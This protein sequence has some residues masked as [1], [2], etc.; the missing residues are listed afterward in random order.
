MSTLQYPLGQFRFDP[1]TCTEQRQ[2]LIREYGI[3]PEKLK[4]AV[5]GLTDE[6][7]DTPYRPGGWTVRQVVHHLPESHMNGYVRLKLA[8]TEE[9]HKAVVAD[10]AAW[11]EL[12]DSRNGPIALSLELF[13][14]LQ[15]RWV[16]ALQTLS[17]PDFE[18]TMWHPAW[19]TVS[20]DYVVQSYAWHARHHI[21]HITGL[22][23]RMGWL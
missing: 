13:R 23:E 5:E 12:N 19:G 20:L 7:L 9:N 1:Q 2:R 4:A 17:D 22:R 18:R 11:A 21:A 8:L 16:V 14:V 10:E 3:F 15:Q 6:Q